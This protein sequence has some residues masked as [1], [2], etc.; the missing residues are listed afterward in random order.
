MQEAGEKSTTN[1]HHKVDRESV[2]AGD[3]FAILGT[4]TSKCP[5]Y[6]EKVDQA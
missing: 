5:S 2:K 4:V 6:L 3:V 1:H